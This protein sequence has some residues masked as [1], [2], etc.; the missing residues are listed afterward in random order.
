MIYQQDSLEVQIEP[1]MLSE[2]SYKAKLGQWNDDVAGCVDATLDNFVQS[3]LTIIVDELADM[4]KLKRKASLIQLFK[5]ANASYSF[6]MN[7]WRCRW[8]GI[9]SNGVR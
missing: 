9:R 2:S 3:H 1:H 6:M 7:L 5:N 4:E 8:I